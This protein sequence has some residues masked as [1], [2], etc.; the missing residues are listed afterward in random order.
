[1]RLKPLFLLLLLILPFN[2][3]FSQDG[4]GVV[5][6]LGLDP[7][8]DFQEEVTAAGQALKDI[9]Y[10]PI[11]LDIKDLKKDPGLWGRMG[12]LWIHRPDTGEFSKNESKEWFADSLKSFVE[13]GGGL[14]LTMDA[15]RLL[16][17]TGIE[18]EP[19]MTWDKKASD[20]GYGRMLGIHGISDHPVFDGLNGGSYINKP[21]EN[22]EIRVLGFKDGKVPA[23]GKVV[24]VDWDYIFVREDKKILMEYQEGKGRILAC[25]AYTIFNQ[26]NVNRQHLEKFLDNALH[27]LEKKPETKEQQYWH[28]GKQEVLEMELPATYRTITVNEPKNW[29]KYT[30]GLSLSLDS[31]TSNYWDIAGRRMFL[32]GKEKAGIDEVWSHPFMAIRDYYAGFTF[33]GQAKTFWLK[34]HTPAIEV[35]PEAFIRTYD[36]DTVKVY[37]IITV[38]P[39]DPLAVIHYEFEGTMPTG[40]VYGFSSNLR[41]M[42]PLSSNV[43]PAIKYAYDSTL[44]A[45][46]ITDKN[47]EYSVILGS[48]LPAI[49]V[50]MG[51]FESVSQDGSNDVPTDLFQVSA[52]AS[53][54]LREHAA[55]DILLSA[56][57]MSMEAARMEYGKAST[58]PLRI[59]RKAVNHYQKIFNQYL[60]LN[61]PDPVF[62]EG[63]QWAIAATD[64]FFVETPGLGTSLVAGYATTARGWDGEHAVNGRPG[65]AWYFGRDGVWSG[66]AVLDYGD[67][68]GVRNMLLMFQKYQDLNGK[69]FHELSTSGFVHYDASDATPLYVVLAG[70]YFKRTGDYKFISDNWT[71]IEKAINYCY[72]TD[73]DGDLLIENTN[74]GHGW[75]EGGHLFG[76]HSSLYLTACWA[77]ALENA[78]GMARFTGK[79][80]LSAKYKKDAMEVRKKLNT[81]FWDE[82][83]HFYHQGLYQDGTPHTEKAIM[84]AIPMLFGMVDSTRAM[85][86]LELF[87]SDDYSSDWGVRI[88][89]KSSEHFNPGGYHTGSVWPL[90]TGWVSLAEY[91][92]G[93]GVQG[94][95]HLMNNLKVYQDWSLGLVEEVLHGS[96][97]KPFG[98]CPHQCWSET[99]VIQPIVEGMLGF[100][101]DVMKNR[102]SLRPNLPANWDYLT[103]KNIR[104]GNRLL[105]MDFRRE[106]GKYVYIFQNPARKPV[107]LDFA[108][109]LPPGTFISDV[110]NN[111]AIIEWTFTETDRATVV[112]IPFYLD[113]TDTIIIQTYGGISVLPQEYD[114]APGEGSGGVR[115]LKTSIADDTYTVEV[116]GENGGMGEVQVWVK[117][118]EVESVEGGKIVRKDGDVFV[119]GVEFPECGKGYCRENIVLRY[120]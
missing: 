25:G 11:I 17:L 51:R 28:Y 94:F 88:T 119:I 81:L 93:R 32:M 4:R 15:V 1:M 110:T 53:V 86:M 100:K 89:G 114:V 58:F 44:N 111:S 69:I 47:E 12:V 66:F 120:K 96:E 102:M 74:V 22:I 61:S 46:L 35:T 109:V 99:M 41:L 7:S 84:P 31:A 45:F 72:S 5:G 60:S 95:T 33:Q 73:T 9:G 50:N 52:T 106:G 59:Y 63:F 83:Q 87:A 101:G 38:D 56:G 90:Y 62:N 30:Q 65:Y 104:F 26:E 57:S 37:E 34:D 71:H 39:E 91:Q 55:V 10:N 3:L 82:E 43:L 48:N 54:D 112:D 97:Y 42:W 18:T 105:S 6:Y 13:N 14:L 8:G 68:E 118:Y 117:D 78:I 29:G 80:E 115:I 2:I 77:K 20:N 79:K 107:R 64:R 108:P 40:L 27:F 92:Y 103:A 76:S 36:L 24:G 21:I 16:N 85:P 98:V 70:E 23:V 113:G 19:F 116:E 67:F 75:V 49:R